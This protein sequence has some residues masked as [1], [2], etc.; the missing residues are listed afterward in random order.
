MTRRKVDRT[1]KLARR[2]TI[3]MSDPFY[4]RMEGWLENSNCQTLSELA[5]SILY[6][7]E[8]IWKHTD[9]SLESAAIELAGIKKELN[10]IGKNI[11]QITHHFHTTDS[12]KEKFYDS[13]R[14]G[15]EYKKVGEKVNMILAIATELSKKWLQG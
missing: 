1:A 12:A 10:A 7:E 15:E 8:I 6:R 2:V 4:K 11:N 3:R 5:R 14:V 13:R 9:S